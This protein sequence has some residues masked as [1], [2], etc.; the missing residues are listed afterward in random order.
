MDHPC[1]TKHVR[2]KP[3]ICKSRLVFSNGTQ[4]V[5]AG[6][7]SPRESRR[8]DDMMYAMKVGYRHAMSMKRYVRRVVRQDIKCVS[9]QYVRVRD[10]GVEGNLSLSNQSC[11]C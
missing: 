3:D 8:C 2:T 10:D 6:N 9:V 5:G 4:A 7:D 11:A 1:T